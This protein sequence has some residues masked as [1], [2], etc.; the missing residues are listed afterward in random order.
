VLIRFLEIKEEDQRFGIM[1]MWKAILASLF[2]T[3]VSQLLLFCWAFPILD[4]MQR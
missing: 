2:I 3:G 1:P 4:A